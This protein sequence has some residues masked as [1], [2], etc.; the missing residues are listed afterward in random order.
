MYDNLQFKPKLIRDQTRPN[1]QAVNGQSLSVIGRVNLTFKMNGLTL[2]HAFYVTNGL[3]RNFILGRDWLKANG[4]RMYF[5]LGCLRIGKTYVTL[6]DDIHVCS[7]LRID[8]DIL[9]KPQTMTINYVKINKGFQIGDSGLLQVNNTDADCIRREPGLRLRDSVY[10]IR[11]ADKLPVIIINQTNR[12][13][14]LRRGEIIGKI[15][16]LDS[17]EI[18]TVSNDNDGTRTVIDDDL[19]DLVVPQE[20]RADIEE[21]ISNH[22]DLFA[23]RDCDLGATGTVKMHIET[24]KC[25]PIKKRPYRTPLNNRRIVDNAIDEMLEAGI[26]ERSKSA[27]AFPLVVVKKKDGSQRMCV[28]FRS[29]NQIVQP[30]SFPLPLIDD[31]LSRL[32][33]TKYF[34]TLD[35][36]SGYWQV[37]LDEDSK[38]KTAFTCHKGLFQFNVMPFGL[39]NAP[40]VFQELMNIVLQGCEEFAT[41]YL[42]DILIFSSSV[43]DHLEHIQF[44][45]DKIREHGLKLKMK[46]MHFL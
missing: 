4:V 1:L 32:G 42:D 17:A 20:Y 13:Y 3:N 45:F 15:S 27:W 39:S 2:T 8:K 44:V 31:I 14:R 10:R 24:G 40:A 36:K 28:D 30:V 5:D 18:S 43:K 26:I 25:S 37:Q 12:H 35:L 22:K 19:K 6:R 23:R 11:H 16:S 46:K 34:T 33:G 21:I 38:E 41:A 7:A 29:L 9:L